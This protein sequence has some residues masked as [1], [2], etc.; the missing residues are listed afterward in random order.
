MLGEPITLPSD[1]VVD[2]SDIKR[3]LQDWSL[4]VECQQ[5]AQGHHKHVLHVHALDIDLV[6]ILTW[7]DSRLE[8][9]RV[10]SAVNDL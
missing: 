10:Q 8:S 7:D 1:D 6:S 5:I 4:H 3:S 9:H 2:S